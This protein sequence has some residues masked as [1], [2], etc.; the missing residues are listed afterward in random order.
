[1]DERQAAGDQ[2]DQERAV[3]T[4]RALGPAEGE[5]SEP[6]LEVRAAGTAA[7]RPAR[8]IREAI[9]PPREHEGV[10]FPKVHLKPAPVRRSA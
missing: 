1:M 7:S 5:R 4:G 9:A 2:L 10:W 8:A 6:G 3:R